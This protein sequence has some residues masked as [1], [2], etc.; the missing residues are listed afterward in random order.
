MPDPVN[1][2]D[3]GPSG[4]AFFKPQNE[5]QACPYGVNPRANLPN[6]ISL[7]PQ[8]SSIDLD[9][10]W[11]KGALIIPEDELRDAL[12]RCFALFVYPLMPVIELGEFF[13]SVENNSQTNTVSLML[14]QAE[15]AA[16]ISYV[17][18]SL[19]ENSDIIA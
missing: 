1:Y 7:P 14:F 15:M 2:E 12:L 4:S 13:A 18:V 9:Y 10:L 5:S 17:D 8:I 16:A 6:Y 11:K 19:L 3:A